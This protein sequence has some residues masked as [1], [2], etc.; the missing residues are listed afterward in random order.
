MPRPLRILAQQMRCRWRAGSGGSSKDWQE[1]AKLSWP[2]LG[3]LLRQNSEKPMPRRIKM[4][5]V[6]WPRGGHV[7]V[8]RNWPNE[9]KVNITKKIEDNLM[10]NFRPR[11][12]DRFRSRWCRIFRFLIARAAQNCCQFLVKKRW[13]L[14]DRATS[15]PAKFEHG[16]WKT[17]AIGATPNVRAHGSVGLRARNDRAGVWTLQ[18]AAISR[19][20]WA[21]GGS[22]SRWLLKGVKTMCSVMCV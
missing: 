4:A 3:D 11:N 10:T 7:F 17:E 15:G 1:S 2:I 14:P 5:M 19:L 22:R 20:A 9:F 16:A 8:A 12:C 13:P 6:L 21:R 18:T